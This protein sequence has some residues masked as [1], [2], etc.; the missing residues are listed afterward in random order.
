MA[1]TKT[2]EMMVIELD[3]ATYTTARAGYYYRKRTGEEKWTRV[4]KTEWDEAFEQNMQNKNDAADVQ[5]WENEAEQERKAREEKQAESDKQAEQAVNGTKKASK[6][7]R[8]KDIAFEGK[9]FAG[10][11]TLTAK[12][13][14]FIK[15]MPQD[16]F[17]EHG[18]DSALWVD[19]YCDTVADQFNP[20]A[21]GA[22]VST[23]REKNLIYVV[24]DRVNGR[25]CKFFSFTE[26]GK[27][28]ARQ[29]GLN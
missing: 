6:P 11:I 16:D 12:Q 5:E 14:A 28:V 15:A 20:M 17:Y 22:M 1:T 9:G 23:L 19:V 4:P 26:T 3:G 7:R 18:L 8:S 21:V 2:N 25:K 24:S 27:E 29:L 10:G 13:V